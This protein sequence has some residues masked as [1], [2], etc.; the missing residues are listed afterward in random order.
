MYKYIHTC[1]YIHIYMSAHI[2]TYTYTHTHIQNVHVNAHKHAWNDSVAAQRARSCCR[3]REPCTSVSFDV[4]K[5]HFAPQMQGL[6]CTHFLNH[7]Y[8][9]T[10]D[11]LWFVSHGESESTHKLGTYNHAHIIRCKI[12]WILR[13]VHLRVCVTTCVCERERECAGRCGCF[14]I[15]KRKLRRAP[16]YV[17]RCVPV[18]FKIMESECVNV[19]YET[20]YVYMHMNFLCVWTY[21]CIFVTLFVLLSRWHDMCTFGLIHRRP[22]GEYL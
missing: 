2:H 9:S 10:Q 3:R 22:C 14:V 18:K 21:V 4:I 1:I 20:G 8:P 7:Q 19:L 11:G 15:C 16:W 6:H 5:P 17:C 13:S 12:V